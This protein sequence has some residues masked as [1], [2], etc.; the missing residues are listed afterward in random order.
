MES[1]LERIKGWEPEAK[2]GLFVIMWDISESLE[3]QA[4]RKIC[5]TMRGL[6]GWGQL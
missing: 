4:I 5:N 2:V 6:V 3:V 1:I